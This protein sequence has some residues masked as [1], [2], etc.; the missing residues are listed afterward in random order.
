MIAVKNAEDESVFEYIENFI[1]RSDY[2]I[3]V[4]VK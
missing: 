3:I 1:G 4:S 2:K